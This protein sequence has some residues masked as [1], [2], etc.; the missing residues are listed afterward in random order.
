MS[1]IILP[2]EGVLVPEG[3]VTQV[4]VSEDTANQEK[5]QTE[6]D[7]EKA[8]VKPEERVLDPSLLDKSLVERMPEPTGWRLL[9]MPYKGRG[10]TEGGILLTHETIERQQIST[11]CAYV[12]KVGP[13]AYRDEKKFPSGPWCQK[14][15][16]VIFARYAGSRFNIDG[17]EVR[18][19]ND[20]EIIGTVLN[21]DDIL[22]SV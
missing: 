1:S 20:D 18:I 5:S 3:A 7:M 15:D 12:L 21:P 4:A 14:G 16:W 11:V 19:L 13:L 17:G 22:T 9:V 10:M 8:Y 6:K 2:P